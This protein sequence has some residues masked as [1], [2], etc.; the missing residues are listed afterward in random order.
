[1]FARRRRKRNKTNQRESAAI[2]KTQLPN[3]DDYAMVAK[4]SLKLKGD[5]GIKK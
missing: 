5:H 4:G 1:M 3:M 2:A